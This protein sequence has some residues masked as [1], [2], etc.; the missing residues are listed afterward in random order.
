MKK[1][2]FGKKLSRSRT[3]RVALVRSLIKAL[4]SNGK[5]TTTTA[6]AKVLRG[7]MEKIMASAK[8][9]DLASRRRIFAFLANDRD[10]SDRIMAIAQKSDK[11]SSFISL[12][13]TSARRGDQAQMSIVELSGWFAR[14][15]KKEPE[16]KNT[17]KPEQKET[18]KLKKGKSPKKIKS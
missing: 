18:K 11:K 14:E 15:V 4:V 7:H 17:Q 13:A 12:Y 1:R 6:K 2:V 5:I 8:K 9:G 3:A 10:T 16:A